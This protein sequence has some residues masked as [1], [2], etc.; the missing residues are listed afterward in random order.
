[1]IGSIRLKQVREGAEDYEYL[2]LLG[3]L[4][5]KADPAN[6]ELTES[7]QALQ[8]ALDVVNIPCAMGRYSTK[9]LK[10]PDDVLRV[11][12]QVAESIEKLINN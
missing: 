3:N 9:I 4:I 7:R 10:T 1:L 8:K 12:K 6:P 11:R 2:S 5:K